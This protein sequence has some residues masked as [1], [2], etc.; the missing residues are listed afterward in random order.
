MARSAHND[1]PHSEA[2]TALVLWR[3]GSAQDHLMLGTYTS[4]IQ[5]I[6]FMTAFTDISPHGPPGDRTVTYRCQCFYE[7]IDAS[8]VGNSIQMPVCAPRPTQG[9]CPHQLNLCHLVPK[10]VLLL[11]L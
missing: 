6:D 8:P 10:R 7:P 4:T 3:P 9:P 5:R 2:C 1:K 11:F